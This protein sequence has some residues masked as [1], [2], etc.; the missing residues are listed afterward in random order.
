M[1]SISVALISF[2][3]S[4]RA[5]AGRRRSGR[6][7]GRTGGRVSCTARRTTYVQGDRV[8]REQRAAPRLQDREHISRRRRE[9]TAGATSTIRRTE[10]SGVQPPHGGGGCDEFI[11]AWSL[12]GWAGGRGPGQSPFR[13]TTCHQI[14]SGPPAFCDRSR[15]C[16]TP[17]VPVTT[18]CT[19]LH[20]VKWLHTEISDC[21]AR[22]GCSMLAR[23]LIAPER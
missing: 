9:M 4:G 5:K 22:S 1:A 18:S 17:L 14:P 10:A 7:D 11:M 20:L 15:S 13:R 8:F 16:T 3:Q 6:K 2:H 23:R 12:L 21:V 19:R